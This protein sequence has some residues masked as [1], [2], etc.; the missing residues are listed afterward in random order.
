[1][2]SLERS[3]PVS[4]NPEHVVV[5]GVKHSKNFRGQALEEALANRVADTTLE[6]TRMIAL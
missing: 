6:K 4:V 1:M 3:L 5:G 2:L